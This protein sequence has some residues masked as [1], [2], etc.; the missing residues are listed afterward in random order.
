LPVARQ[1]CR[2]NSASNCW[3]VWFVGEIAYLPLAGGKW[4]YLATWPHL[5]SRK[6][7]GWQVAEALTAEL[8]TGALRQSA[9][10]ERPARGMIAH[11]DRGGQCVADLELISKIY[12]PAE[13]SDRVSTYRSSESAI[14]IICKR[15][16]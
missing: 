14:P 13:M 5:Y 1:G 16:F 9:T 12:E 6:V 10:W 11:S 3:R 8:V 15:K 2:W 4:A 7:I